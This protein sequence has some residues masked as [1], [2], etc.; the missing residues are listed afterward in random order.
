MLPFPIEDLMDEQ[1]CYEF[2]KEVLHPD[3]LHCPKGHSL[4]ADQ[5]PHDRTRTP[6]V[7]YRCRECGRVFNI[8]TN[9]IFSNISFSSCEIVLLLRGI[10]QGD[11]TTHIAQE[12]DRDYSNLLT[13]RHR[14]QKQGL[15]NRMAVELTDEAV[16]VDE[17][18][19]N[20]GH[21]GPGDDDDDQMPPRQRANK[22]R[23]RGTMDTDRPP[24]VGII[25]RQSNQMRIEV[26]AD[27]RQETVLPLVE[28]TTA[29]DATVYTDE[30]HT[31]RP[32]AETGRDHHT[33]SHGD[34]EWARDEDGDGVNEVHTNTIEGSW[35]QW[36][37]FMRPF[38]GLHQKYL[39]QY[40]VVFE[41]IHNLKAV[42]MDCLRSLLIPNFTTEPI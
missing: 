25:G 9:T 12:L 30:A 10:V 15:A 19:Q 28:K 13:W 31:Y 36:R 40:A 14:L 20:S 23:G 5:A 41:W 7:S 33:V 22:R 27:A 11:P 18:Y 16:E 34:R 26:C 32:L 1:A 38:R 42:T 8:F 17:V 4:P 3:S 37:N 29:P 2:L 24:V 6:I 39:S 21:K 35:T